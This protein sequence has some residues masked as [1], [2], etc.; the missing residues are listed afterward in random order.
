MTEVRDYDPSWPAVAEAAR[1]E[2]LAACPGVFAEIEHVGST[3]VPGLAAKPIID[4]MASIPTLDDA[5]VDRLAGLDFQLLDVGMAGRLFFIR[6]RDGVRTHHLHVVPADTWAH[7]NE[8]LLRDHLR[9]SP[10]DARAYG[11]L[12]QR[13][14]T[15]GLEGEA[16]TRAKTALIQTLTDRARAAYGLPSVPVWE[17]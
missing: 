11:E 2:V 10:E 5:P 17:D 7:R 8:R 12:K 16:Y 4:L 15:E 14:A 3:S 9:A 6:D 1:A 13:L